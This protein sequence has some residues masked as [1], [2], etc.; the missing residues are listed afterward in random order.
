MPHAPHEAERLFLLAINFSI[1]HADNY[2]LAPGRGCLRLA[3]TRQPRELLRSPVL[4]ARIYK[5]SKWGYP[6]YPLAKYEQVSGLTVSSLPIVPRYRSSHRDPNTPNTS[7]CHKLNS[8][9]VIRDH[10]DC[11]DRLSVER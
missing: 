8:I 9:R 6:Q 10:S 2:V 1:A 3:I 4:I 11:S 5:Q 7:E